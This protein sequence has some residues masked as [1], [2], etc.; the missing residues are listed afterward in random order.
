MLI[1]SDQGH[2]SKTWSWSN[3]SFRLRC[4]AVFAGSVCLWSL[5]AS[6]RHIRGPNASFQF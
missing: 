5:S 3:S 6:I 1:G 4:P 2:D